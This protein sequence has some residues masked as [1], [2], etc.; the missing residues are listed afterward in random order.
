MEK[1]DNARIIVK[2][3]TPFSIKDTTTRQKISKEIKDVNNI[4][5]K[6]VLTDIYSISHPTTA[7]YMFLSAHE[8]F[9]RLDYKLD[10]KTSQNKF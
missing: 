2:L 8:T 1:Y 7:G 6:L 9:Y 10:H 5:N 4:V 3:N